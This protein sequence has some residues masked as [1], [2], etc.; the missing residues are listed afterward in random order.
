MLTSFY[1]QHNASVHFHTRGSAAAVLQTH[2]SPA[3]TLGRMRAVTSDTPAPP[4]PPPQP[5]PLD[6]LPAGSACGA[7]RPPC[8]ALAAWEP[9]GRAAQTHP[10]QG[11]PPRWGLAG[12]KVS[13][14]SDTSPQAASSQSPQRTPASKQRVSQH[15]LTV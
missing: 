15:G 11:I 13:L 6:K 1:R 8:S 2:S 3:Q 5:Q 10:N 12:G 14:N 7:A 4:A 9:P